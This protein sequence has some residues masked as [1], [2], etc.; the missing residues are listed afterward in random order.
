MDL[1]KSISLFYKEGKSDKEYRIFI[2]PKGSKYLVTFA[3]GRRG[4]SLTN[5]KKTENPVSLE[6][7][8]EIYDK[9]VHKQ[10]LKGYSEEEGAIPYVG[11]DKEERIT[12]V[13]PQLLNNVEEE[14]LEKLFADNTYCMQE[15]K[16]GKRILLRKTDEKLEAINRKGLLVG[17]PSGLEIAAKLINED[18]I[19]DGELIGDKFW[20]FDVLE[21]R[22]FNSLIMHYPYKQR[23]SILTSL[24]NGQSNIKDIQ[25]LETYT[26]SVTKRTA[27]KIIK[28][29]GGEGVVFKKMDA[30]YKPGRPSS[31]GTQLKFKFVQMATCIV[32]G[33]GPKG[34]RSVEIG[35]Y[36]KDGEIAPVGKV[37]VLPNFS[38]PKKGSLIEVKYLYYNPGGALYQPIFCGKR[39]DK[40]KPDKISSL[41]A[42]QAIEEEE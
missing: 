34:K 21:F 8:T 14:G 37:T 11:S 36:D 31:G 24:F 12:G 17:F 1:V 25:L 38:V 28:E 39:E 33:P 42:K 10:R 2:E 27:F 9:L 18:F 13:L 35:L 20:V 16:D 19:L 5:G 32:L 4:N 40:D 22:G 23:N 41:K 30:E 3:Y 29:Q 7:A 26:T 6:E 15:K